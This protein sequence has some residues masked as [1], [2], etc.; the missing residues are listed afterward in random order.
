MNIKKIISELHERRNELM[1]KIDKINIAIKALQDIYG[2]VIENKKENKKY[3][4]NHVDE[5]M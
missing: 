2:D 5:I 4:I 3:N 1:E